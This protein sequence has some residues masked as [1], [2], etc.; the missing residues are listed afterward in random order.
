MMCQWVL[1]ATAD[2]LALFCVTAF[3]C[4]RSEMMQPENSRLLLLRLNND[5]R[6]AWINQMISSDTGIQLLCKPAW[7]PG[8]QSCE[9]GFKIFLFQVGIDKQA[10]RIILKIKA[11]QNYHCAVR[12]EMTEIWN[13]VSVFYMRKIYIVMLHQGSWEFHIVP[14]SRWIYIC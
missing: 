5:N 9:L 8:W 10:E 6:A 14:F 12:N 7:S 2:G 1:N 11:G 4:P 3:S 13:T